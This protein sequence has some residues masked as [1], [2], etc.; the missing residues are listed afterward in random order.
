MRK[1][2]VRLNEKD[3]LDFL[4]ESNEYSEALQKQMKGRLTTYYRNSLKG[5]TEQPNWDGTVIDGIPAI[6]DAVEST[7]EEE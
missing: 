7:G 5:I 3:Y 2:T 1:I 4:L 6:V